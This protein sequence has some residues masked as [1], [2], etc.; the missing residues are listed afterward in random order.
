MVPAAGSYPTRGRLLA[1]PAAAPLVDTQQEDHTFRS[2][3]LEGPQQGLEP[4]VCGNAGVCSAMLCSLIATFTG[5]WGFPRTILDRQAEEDGS[6]GAGG[7]LRPI[8]RSRRGTVEA[9]VGR[10][11]RAL[12]LCEAR[13][14]WRDR[15]AFERTAKPPFHRLAPFDASNV[16]PAKAGTALAS[17]ANELA[18]RRLTSYVRLNCG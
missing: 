7:P 9:V 5:K 2:P 4:P 15:P 8:S 11:M 17:G 1:I 18:G 6:A 3:L 13:T 14:T 10:S 12:D 16:I